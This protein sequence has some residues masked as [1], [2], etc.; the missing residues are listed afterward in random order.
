MS[1]RRSLKD[2][3]SIRA[4]LARFRRRSRRSAFLD[5]MSSVLDLAP[6]P[7]L[8]EIPS[9]RPTSVEEALRRDA[10]ATL[11]DFATAFDATVATHAK[12]L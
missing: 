11:R 9:N 7:V 12:S 5:G 2:G 3:K 4:N 1:I 8:P 10:S 6:T